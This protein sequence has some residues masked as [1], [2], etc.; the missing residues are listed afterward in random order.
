MGFFGTLF[1][2]IGEV[3]GEFK[4]FA[5]NCSIRQLCENIIN[6][7]ASSEYCKDELRSR[8]RQMSKSDLLDTYDEY[9]NGSMALEM[10][11]LDEFETRGLI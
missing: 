4:K 11:F 6:D 1:E 10:I 9:S 2:I 3:D 5:R 8:L 7:T